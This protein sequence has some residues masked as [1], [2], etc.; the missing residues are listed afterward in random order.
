MKRG[1]EKGEWKKG[2]GKRGMEKG[3]NK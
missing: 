1:T 2:N 3:G